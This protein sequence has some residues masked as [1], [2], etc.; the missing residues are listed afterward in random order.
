MG[1]GDTELREELAAEIER[2][3]EE[4]PALPSPEDA[5]GRRGAAARGLGSTQHYLAGSEGAGAVEQVAPATAGTVLL[6]AG[7]AA[8]GG[9]GIVLLTW[10]HQLLAGL[11]CVA[12][13]A[14][15]IG[16]ADRRLRRHG[17]ARRTDL[18]RDSTG[19]PQ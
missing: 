5:A 15:L 10:A 11:V 6:L 9:A 8:A 7:I 12:I 2:L 16:V 3:C 4:S 18:S 13:A 14:A 17:A 19:R 1:L